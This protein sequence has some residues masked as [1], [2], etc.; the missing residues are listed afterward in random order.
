VDLD[1]DGRADIISG[2]FPGEIYF[3]K[4]NADG[5]FAAPVKLKDKSGAMLNVG[6]ASSVA[7]GDWDGD[8]VPDLVI[9]TIDGAVFKVHNDGT[10]E[11]PAFGKAEKLT[12][13]S[14]PE[15]DAGPCLADWDGD[16]RLDLLLG[17]GSGE[18]RLFRNTGSARQPQWEESSVLVAG[19]R[20]KRPTEE[21]FE[22]PTRSGRR[23][24][25]AV[26]DW[27]GDGK[28]DLLV[29]DFISMPERKFHGWVWVYLRKV[30]PTGRDREQG[31]QV[32]ERNSDSDV[33]VRELPKEGEFKEP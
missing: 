7:V 20:Q 24:K 14:A 6:R 11:K 8:G 13:I 31:D 25:V 23:S 19:H 17:S 29:G 10:K 33:D 12:N 16:G 21:E 26:A 32:R 4:R 27:N 5:S 28:P 2:S 1:G 18:V 15:G 9:G 22:N 3:F 30:E